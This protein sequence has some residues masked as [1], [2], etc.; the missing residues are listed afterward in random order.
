MQNKQ[1]HIRLGEKEHKILRIICIHKGLSIQE[2]TSSL[3]KKY[4]SENKKCLSSFLDK[5]ERKI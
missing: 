4:L 3:I 2:L 5:D 1:I